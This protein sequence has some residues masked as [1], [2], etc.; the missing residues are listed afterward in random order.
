M[1]ERGNPITKVILNEI[2][3]NV[4]NSL[5]TFVLEHKKDTKYW[6]GMESMVVTQYQERLNYLLADKGSSIHGLESSQKLTVSNR[7]KDFLASSKEKYES[8]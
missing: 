6:V 1:T 3:D 7:I 2:L 5:A 4:E 8:N